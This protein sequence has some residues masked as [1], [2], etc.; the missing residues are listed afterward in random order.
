MANRLISFSYTY[1][2][3]QGKIATVNNVDGKQMDSVAQ[4]F[5][6]EI[7]VSGSTYNKQQNPRTRNLTA[8]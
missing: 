7:K 2:D 4:S 1:A 8:A 3:E 6:D 5:R